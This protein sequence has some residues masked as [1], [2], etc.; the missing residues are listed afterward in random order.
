MY[1]YPIAKMTSS[2]SY[3]C[4]NQEIKLTDSSV[5]KEGVGKSYWNFGNGDKDTVLPYTVKYKFKTPGSFKVQLITE[6]PFGC[7]DTI[8][9]TFVVQ[10]SPINVIDV[11]TYSA[12]LKTNLFDFTDKSTISSG[13]YTTSWTYGKTPNTSTNSAIKGVKFT[14]TGWQLVILK[15]TSSFG[16]ADIDTV[17]VRINP[18]PKAYFVVTDS[19]TC[20]A[21]NFFNLDDASTA[22]KNA[23]LATKAGWKYQDG[24]MNLAKTVLNKKFSS[25]GKYWIRIISSTTDGCL[26]SFQREVEVYAMP[27]ADITINGKTQCLK[28]INTF[29][30]RSIHML[31]PLGFTFGKPVMEQAVRVILLFIHLRLL[32]HFAYSIVLNPMKVVLIQHQRL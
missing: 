32:A 30:N 3:F 13:T 15:N 29:S 24:T 8:D 11:K 4:Q 10:P 7:R 14:D 1:P 17:K 23:T 27:Q 5:S 28:G 19:S 22:P 25:P 18:E 20:F 6:T 31:D 12:C 2:W 26:D 16:C 9:S 21:G